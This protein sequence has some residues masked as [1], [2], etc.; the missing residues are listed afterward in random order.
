[1]PVDH[2]GGYFVPGSFQHCIISQM[3]RHTYTCTHNS[4]TLR[5]SPYPSPST[6]AAQVDDHSSDHWY[7][8][9]GDDLYFQDFLYQV[10]MQTAHHLSQRITCYPTWD[11]ILEQ[12]MVE[13]TF[14]HEDMLSANAMAMQ[15]SS[16]MCQCLLICVE[17]L[18]D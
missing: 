18:E 7:W 10:Q 2:S 11:Q 16:A 6:I 14:D 17:R 1:M 12:L 8:H 5:P 3:T 9:E 15:H 13:G 4:S